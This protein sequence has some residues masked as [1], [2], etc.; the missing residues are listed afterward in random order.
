MNKTLETNQSK[1]KLG[2][3]LAANFLIS[4]GYAILEKNYR[5]G[6][7]EIDIICLK[8][9]VLIF[10]EVK[11]RTSNAF[12]FPEDFVDAKKEIRI[13]KAAENYILDKNWQKDIRFDII[14][15][16]IARENTEITHLQDVFV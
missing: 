9:G 1:G 10:V 15:V 5:F 6:R 8:N 3:N 13:R 16:E 2:E 4:N 14:S 11:T 12:G 7:Y